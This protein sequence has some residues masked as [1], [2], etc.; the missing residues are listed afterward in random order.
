M[1]PPGALLWAYL[2]GS[3]AYLIPLAVLLVVLSGL[4]TEDLP[5][6]ALL[7]PAVVAMAAVAY[8]SVGFALEF[9]GVGLLDPRHGFSALVWE[10]SPL[11]ESWGV[12]WGAMGFAGWFLAGDAGT[13]EAVAL[14][15]GHLA[16]AITTA[17]L[18]AVALRRRRGALAPLILALV[19]AGVAEPV[20]G[21]W[22]HGGGWLGRLGL[23]LGLGQG[24]VDFGGSGVIGIVGGS[25]GLAAL[26]AF[27]CRRPRETTGTL[28]TV[29]WPAFAAMGT[30]L[31]LVGSIG[32]AL[33][34]PLYPPET[35]PMPRVV[36]NGLLGFAGGAAIPALY[37]W[38]VAGRW[39]PHLTF[40][41]GFAGWLSVLAGLPYLSPPAALLLG[42]VTGLLM[43][44]SVY[45][46]R[47][48]LRLDDPAGIITGAW[49]GGAVGVLGVG[50]LADGTYALPWM[51][52]GSVQ[53]IW[54][55]G[56]WSPDALPQLYAQALGLAA[57][58]VW[59]FLVGS[60]LS[61]AL[62]ALMY[63]LRQMPLHAQP[64]SPS[65]ASASPAL[66]PATS[67]DTTPSEDGGHPPDT[68]VPS[69]PSESTPPETPPDS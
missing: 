35:L 52:T 11:P 65:P 56:A 41:G 30:L 24:F 7:F 10:W 15:V 39:H 8:A 42:L 36:A 57:L 31:F 68:P 43:P 37:V 47:E 62:A 3:L 60:V 49:V 21:N 45:L 64:T 18:A 9:G 46:V 48:M 12:Y 59:G 58:T 38:F 19:A 22:V 1:T 26:L 69:A 32:W 34:N 66:T 33:H 53:G 17:W 16:W 40:V 55:G 63:A 44:F 4:T 5:T 13:A 2:G 25:M 67:A 23:S 50:L 29:P 6:T 27:R 20:A 14:F 51:A 61:V 54:A 28:P